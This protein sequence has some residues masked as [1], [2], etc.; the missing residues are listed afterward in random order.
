GCSGASTS[1]RERPMTRARGSA[2]Q[3][4]AADRATRRRRALRRVARRAFAAALDDLADLADGGPDDPVIHLARAEAI[5][6]TSDAATALP[7]FARARS[8]SPGCLRTRARLGLA[9]IEAGRA[10]DGQAELDAVIAALPV[11]GAIDAQ[12]APLAKPWAFA[13]A[14]SDAALQLGQ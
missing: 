9:L 8:G 13:P 7:H 11:D 4:D 1:A 12:A 6:G 5:W 2:L 10:A 14:P 3:P